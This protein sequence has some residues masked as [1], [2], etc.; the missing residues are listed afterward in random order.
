MA[1]AAELAQAPVVELSTA[2]PNRV[3]GWTDLSRDTFGMVANVFMDDREYVPELRWPLSVRRTFPRMATDSQLKALMRGTTLPITRFAWGIDPNGARDELVAA[4]CRDYN[5]PLI[6]DAIAEKKAGRPQQP[7]GRSR[8]R[9]SHQRHLAE[10]FKALENGHAYFEQPGYIGDDGYWHPA[11]IAGIPARTIAQI[12]VADDGGLIGIRQNGFEAPLLEV[13]RL[14]VYVWDPADRGDWI[15]QSMYRACF[16]EWLIKDRLLRVD[17]RNHEKAGGMWWGEAHKDATP[18]EKQALAKIAEQ[19]NALTG[20]T[21]VVANGDALHLERAGGGPTTIES[22]NR[23]D[24]AMTRPFL[25][26][27]LQLGSSRTGA[28]AVGDSFNELWGQAQEAIADWHRDTFNE[29][30]LEDYVDW[31]YGPDEEFAPRL[32][33]WRPESEAATAVLDQ[34]MQNDPAVEAAVQAVRREIDGP[35]VERKPR[36]KLDAARAAATPAPSTGSL[37]LPDRTLRRQPYDHEIAA[38]V[39]FAK[40]DSDWQATVDSLID[41]WKSQVRA[42]QIAELHQAIAAAA[43]DLEKLAILE[44][45]AAGADLIHS[46]L[47]TAAEAGAAAALQEAKDQGVPDPADADLTLVAGELET[48]AA[49]LEQLLARS[50]SQ[51]AA[52]KAVQLTGGGLTPV[53]VADETRDYLDG[54]TDSYLSDQFGGV[55]TAAQNAGRRAVMA[56][57]NPSRVYASELLDT[58]TCEPCRQVDGKEYPSLE[59]AAADYPAGGYRLCKGGPRCRG[60]EVAVYEEAQA[61]A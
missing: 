60:T 29:H 39:D 49:A 13:A 4:V 57:N 20:G 5:L 2:F 41:E 21:P 61:S 11:K 36:P 10:S 51:A 24:E 19:A 31:N 50:L 37:P 8:N 55:T 42:G 46:R 45:A 9:L 54:L 16:R 43:G 23:H 30:V 58:N 15:G 17:A 27:L 6:D 32:V 34:A 59:A 14:V 38:K 33:Y 26:M 40:L 28:R 48:R 52:A 12:Y 3:P 18:A 7:V 44:A 35:S 56:A 47:T 25:L 22:I 1:A 53:E